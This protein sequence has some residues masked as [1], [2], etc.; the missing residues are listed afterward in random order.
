[1]A[2]KL[3]KDL[4][5]CVAGWL[6]T[7]KWGARFAKWRAV[8]ALGDGLPSRG[9]MQANAHSL[10]RY[11]ALC[12]EAGLVPIV[13][14]EVLMN[15]R[16]TIEECLAA[17]QEMLHIVFDQLYQQTIL[18]EGMLLKPNMI[19]PGIDCSLQKDAHIVAQAT[20]KCLLMSVPAAVPGI[21]FLSGGQ[22]AEK[23]SAGLD[24]INGKYRPAL[25]WALTFSFGRVATTDFG[26][27]I[28]PTQ[29]PPNKCYIIGLM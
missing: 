23:A 26:T 2:K 27:A 13:E 24:A 12:Q 8:I 25:P 6:N 4:K 21:A 5:V 9:C 29:R 18:L 1:M 14:P 15:G 10:A 17:T 22:P 20:I 11:A 19:L 7:A 16:H 28:R 3:R